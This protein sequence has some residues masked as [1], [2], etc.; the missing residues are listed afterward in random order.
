MGSEGLEIEYQT[1]VETDLYMGC[2]VVRYEG[3]TARSCCNER[4]ELSFKYH[5]ASLLWGLQSASCLAQ[6]T[7]AE[8][9]ESESICQVAE[10]EFAPWWS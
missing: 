6:L 9:S 4:E 1:Y 8:A 5:K 3:K 7:G 10:Y 2:M